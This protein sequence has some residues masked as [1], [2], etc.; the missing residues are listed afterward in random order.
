MK[1]DYDAEDERMGH[2]R[3]R[4]EGRCA[5]GVDHCVSEGYIA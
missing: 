2:E 3:H 5:V 4:D 1:P